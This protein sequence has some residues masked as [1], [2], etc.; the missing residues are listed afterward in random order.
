MAYYGVGWS[1]TMR[2]P[3][4]LCRVASAQASEVFPLDSTRSQRT[5]LGTHRPRPTLIDTSNPEVPHRHI[6]THATH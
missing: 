4:S 5:T 1:P 6:A 3:P 2:R